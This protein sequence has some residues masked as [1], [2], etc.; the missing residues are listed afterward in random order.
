M[1]MI[2]VPKPVENRDTDEVQTASTMMAMVQAEPM[3]QT[4]Q[5]GQFI[6]HG[7]AGGD[8]RLSACCR[9]HSR[10]D[11]VATECSNETGDTASNWRP[12]AEDCWEVLADLP[13]DD[14][15]GLESLQSDAVSAILESS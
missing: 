1:L 14:V 4:A 8:V 6:S 12:P 13:V 15:G 2:S 3:Y 10:S 9:P 7:L 5:K 11:I